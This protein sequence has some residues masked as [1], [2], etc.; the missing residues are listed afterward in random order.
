MITAHFKL[1]SILAITTLVGC[2]ITPDSLAPKRV[3]AGCMP[4]SYTHLISTDESFT[5]DSV[6]LAYDGD[7]KIIGATAIHQED[8]DIIT[9]EHRVTYY[10]DYLPATIQ[11]ENV[12]QSF[13]YNANDQLVRYTY[14]A[15]QEQPAVYSVTYDTF[16][17]IARIL[18]E[19]GNG[20]SQYDYNY[21][22]TSNPAEITE[23][24]INKDGSAYTYRTVRFAVDPETTFAL[25]PDFFT[26]GVPDMTYFGFTGTIISMQTT[27]EFGPALMIFN[28]NA[29]NADGHIT[30]LSGIS[31]INHG[32]IT[33]VS[34]AF[35]YTCH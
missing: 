20:A 3:A 15:A 19:D 13:E 26:P 27:Y 8:Y 11:S 1:I 31:Q 9:S 16:G 22:G 32:M 29:Y 10:N 33:F 2:T 34:K 18:K 12:Q 5:R 7:G 23:T 21:N 6:L 35:T 14:Q 24:I 17:K 28:S 30:H 25:N 4:E